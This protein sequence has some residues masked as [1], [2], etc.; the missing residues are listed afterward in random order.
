MYRPR[1]VDACRQHTEEERSMLNLDFS[2][3]VVI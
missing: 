1:Q 3:T 2:Q